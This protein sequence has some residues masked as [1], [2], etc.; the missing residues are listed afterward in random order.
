MRN[1]S[2]LGEIPSLVISLGGNIFLVSIFARA[3]LSPLTHADFIFKTGMMLF[4][5]EFLSIH[6]GGMLGAP[7]V[8]GQKKKALFI[9][10][11]IGIPITFF[12]LGFYALFVLVFGFALKSWFIPLFFLVSLMMKVFSNKVTHNPFSSAISIILLIFSVMVVALTSPILQMLFP[13]PAEVL[14]QKMPNSSGLFIDAPQTLLV[15]GILYFSFTILA[16]IILFW[17][18]RARMRLVPIV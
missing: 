6:S 11:M 15:W 16:D 3:L 14:E 2:H 7:V 18:G 10:K 4:V 8:E 9:R 5:V 13:F 12:L 1:G 17:K